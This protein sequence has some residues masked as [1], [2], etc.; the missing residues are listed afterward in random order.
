M[1]SYALWPTS[2]PD[3]NAALGHFR[4]ALQ[5]MLGSQFIG[6][7]LYGSLALGDFDP[8]GSDIDILVVTDGE[9]SPDKL[10]ALSELHRRFDASGSP[11]AARVEAA[12]VPAA[13]LQGRDTGAARYP[14][15]EKGEAVVLLPLEDGWPFQCHSL[16]EH[17]VT[18]IGPDPHALVAPVSYRA[19]REAAAVIV[20]DWLA[21]SQRDPEWLAWLQD[22]TGQAFVVLTLCRLL[23]TLDAGN[24]ASKPR[25]ARAAALWPAAP[26]AALIERSLAQQRR[27][28]ET[29]TQDVEATLALLRFTAARLGLGQ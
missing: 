22:R 12:Y 19:M 24:V 10:D 3:V 13:V 2:Y 4:D 9:L 20:S 29:P 21:L 15:V 1:A 11:W 17:G 27:H 8:A 23:Y 14:Q 28:V 6:M 7:Y 16:R 5:V 18:V 25:A 26:W